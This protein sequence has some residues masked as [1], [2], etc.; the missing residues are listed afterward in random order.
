[1]RRIPFLILVVLAA[2][3]SISIAPTT[4]NGQFAPRPVCEFFDRTGAEQVGWPEPGSV[5]AG[6]QIRTIN[7]FQL[8]ECNDPFPPRVNWNAELCIERRGVAV[9]SSFRTAPSGCTFLYGQRSDRVMTIVYTCKRPARSWIY[10]T[11]L[12]L[13]IY[14]THGLGN[15]KRWY[16]NQVIRRCA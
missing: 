12:K 5:V 1:M 6:R 10:R 16:S 8:I 7:A 15:T 11:K 9:G 13:I 4:A 3:V 14:N 2:I